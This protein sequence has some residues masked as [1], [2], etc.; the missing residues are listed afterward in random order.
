MSALRSRLAVAAVPLLLACGLLRFDV[1]ESSETTVEGGGLVSQLLEALDFT[2]LDD[3]DVAIDQELADQGVA[4]GDLRSVVL[5]KLELV[6]EPD[7]SYISSMDVYVQANGIDPVL[8]ASGE[9]FPAGQST[10]ALDLTGED[11]T[12]LVVAGGM[13]FTANVSG[14][15]P[16][17]DRKITVNVA[18]QVE[19]TA[20][21]ACNAAKG[22]D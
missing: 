21:G 8:V 22:R 12:D 2:G 11:L 20:Q 5:T 19:A 14:K 10:V 13:S 18:V 1:E 4:E 7:L 15:P 16:S 3:F 9:S 17:T 6:S